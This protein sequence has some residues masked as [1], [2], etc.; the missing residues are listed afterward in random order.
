VGGAGGNAVNRMAE[1]GIHGVELISANSDA[2]A[3]RNN[4]AELKIQVGETLTRGLGVGGD[5]NRGKMAA[6]ETEAPLREALS[7]ADLVFITAGMGGGTGTGG[8]PF[9]GKL[10]KD[11]RALTIGV[12][13]RPFRFEGLNRADIAEQGIQEMRESV[14][15]LLVIPN[16]KL[17][18][19]ADKDTSAEK[20]FHMADD[21]LRKAIQ[22]ISDVITKHGMVNMDLNDLRNIMQNSG[23][24]LIGMGEAFGQGRAVRAAKEA[25]ES[26]L[27]ENVMID[28]AKGV[29]VNIT[30]RKNSLNLDEL[31][32]IM[33]FI[34]G[35]ASPD[36]KIKFGTAYDDLLEDSLRVTVI[37]TGFPPRGRHPGRAAL[38]KMDTSPYLRETDQRFTSDVRLLAGSAAP[39]DWAKPAFMRL[40]TRKLK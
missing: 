38:R 2:Q 39:E 9:V 7:G 33:I 29:I 36:A 24:A 27:L 3:L 12:V 6:M 31:N 4:Q 26:P 14:D 15:A 23:E 5:A 17:L 10:A 20:A 18:E 21:V 16:E 25:V 37:A 34:Q 40:K 22:S 32:E 35:K 30:S 11:M 1:I 19:I 28:G 8:A 13:T